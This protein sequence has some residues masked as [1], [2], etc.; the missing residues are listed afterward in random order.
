[1]RLLAKFGRGSKG[2]SPT[3]PASPTSGGENA[4]ASTNNNNNNVATADASTNTEVPTPKG[5]SKSRTVSEKNVPTAKPHKEK[6]NQGMSI[7]NSDC[8]VTEE[9]LQT[10]AKERV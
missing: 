10:P 1:M 5:R 6:A 8:A 3:N 7:I 2:N 9:I 4:T